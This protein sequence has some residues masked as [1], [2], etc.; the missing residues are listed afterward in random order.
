MKRVVQGTSSSKLLKGGHLID[1]LHGR[2]EPSD[3]L[4]EDGKVFAVAKPG[5]LDTKASRLKAEKIDIK[6]AYI[7]PG[8]IDLN[9]RMGEPGADPRE[10]LNRGA[11]SAAAGG[12]TSIA[13]MPSFSEYNDNAFVTDFISRQAHEESCVRVFP[14]GSLTTKG[15]GEYLA[16]IGT[17]VHTGVVAVGDD[18]TCIKNSYLM[19][20]AIEYTKAFNV[21]VFSFPQDPALVGRGVMDEGLNSCRL[22]LRGIP[23]AAEEVIVA[24]DIT[25][26]Q[27][28]C[29]RLHFSSISTK[30][31]LELI[32]TAKSEGV[33]ITAET[34]PQYFSLTSDMIRTYDSN[35]KCFPPLRGE[36]HVEAIT[37]ALGDGTLDAIASMHMP[38][39]PSA[40]DLV[41][42]DAAAGMIAFETVLPLVLELVRKER[43]SLERMVYLLSTGPAKVIGLHEK[44][45]GSL[46]VGAPAD[47]VIFD[48][49][50]QYKYTSDR[51]CSSAK[52]SP[53]I[54]KTLQG[55]VLMTIVGGEIVNKGTGNDE[56]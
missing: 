14:I 40:K 53:F 7:A 49:D 34:N 54:G 15:K 21:P 32:R 39:S 20:K 4:L 11:K 48:T 43:I 42:E 6:G 27:H 16:E 17:M 33:Q 9:A 38:Q 24:R 45:L 55:V 12:F 46:K 36:D 22:G 35:F 50:K 1:P 2:N 13:C 19:R 18:S 5:E 3:L 47:I 51:V 10:A 30:G 28:A 26:T 41:F 31:S 56:S 52:N 8:F 37:T 25:L 44:G 23:A 29:G